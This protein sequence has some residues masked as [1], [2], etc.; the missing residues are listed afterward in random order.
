MKMERHL[1][2]EMVYEE[3]FAGFSFRCDFKSEASRRVDLSRPSGSLKAF[4]DFKVAY[5]GSITINLLKYNDVVQLF[6][7]IPPVCHDA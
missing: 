1:I 7:G 2:H 5:L 3:G 6:K 4:S